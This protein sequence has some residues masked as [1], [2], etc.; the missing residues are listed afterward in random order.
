MSAQFLPGTT[1]GRWVCLTDSFGASGR[2]LYTHTAKAGVLG[3]IAAW[4]AGVPV[5]VHTFHGN[6]RLTIFTSGEGWAIR[7]FE[8]GLACRTDGICVLAPQQLQS[9]WTATTLPHATRFIS[10]H[11]AWT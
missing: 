9:W 1:F 11:L 4:L 8:R 10:F 6:V 5:I 2:R 3:K 7:L